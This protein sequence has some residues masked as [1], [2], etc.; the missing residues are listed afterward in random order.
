MLEE[1]V[2]SKQRMVNEEEDSIVE[3]GTRSGCLSRP[4]S[5]IAIRMWLFSQQL[6]FRVRRFRWV[7][8]QAIVL[9]PI[10]TTIY[11]YSQYIFCNIIY[12]VRRRNLRG[13]FHI[14]LEHRQLGLLKS[15]SLLFWKPIIIYL[16]DEA[17]L[18]WSWA[19]FGTHLVHC[20]E[21]RKLK[22]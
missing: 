13:Y 7:I 6:E 3:G 5:S 22:I 9:E 19:L 11:G 1:F 18:K 21:E 2:P 8:G 17:L 14:T 15:H 16:D 4:V 12:T 20:D 10:T